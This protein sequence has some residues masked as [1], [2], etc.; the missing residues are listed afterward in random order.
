MIDIEMQKLRKLSK[1]EIINFFMKFKE[2]LSSH[3]SYLSNYDDIYNLAID[4]AISDI[5][6]ENDVDCNFTIERYLKKHI[7]ESLGIIF[8]SMQNERI[9]LFNEFLNSNLHFTASNKNN[10]EE[11][12][13]IADFFKDINYL[14]TTDNALEIIEGNKLL[15][16]SLKKLVDKNI[17]RI[18][19]DDFSSV[20]DN[21][22]LISFMEAYCLKNDISLVENMELT[23][24]YYETILDD[25]DS[26]CISDTVRAYLNTLKKT[27]LTP[28]EEF[29]LAKK[30]KQGDKKAETELIER[31]LRLV[32]AIAKHYVGRG[33]PFIDLIQEGNIGLIKAISKFDPDKGY[34]LSTY[35]T[36][37]IKQAVSR[38]I[39]DNSRTIRMPVHF[40]E[41]LNKYVK[42]TNIL[43]ERLGR[44]PTV[45]ELAKELKIPPDKV[46]KLYGLTVNSISINA[47][48]GANKDRE[49]EVFLADDKA[50]IEKDYEQEELKQNVKKLIENTNLSEQEE[51]V[52][53]L[54]FGIDQP[55]EQ[56]LSLETISKEFGVTRERIRQIEVRALKKL[57]RSRQINGL[58]IY[59]DN[60]EKALENLKASR[61]GLI[62]QNYQTSIIE[63]PNIKST[64]M[65]L[66]EILKDYKEKEIILAIEEII[67]DKFSDLN[68]EFK[69]KLKNLEIDEF[70]AS[71]I[72]EF[73]YVIAPIVKKNL[74]ENKNRESEMKLIN[75]KTFAELFEGYQTEKVIETIDG[76]ENGDLEIFK[77]RFGADYDENISCS[78]SQK[79]RTRLNN[80]IVTVKRKIDR[81]TKEKEKLLKKQ[82]KG[83]VVMKESLLEN[84]ENITPS[85][86]NEESDITVHEEVSTDTGSVTT[87]VDNLLEMFNQPEYIDLLKELNPLEYV[88]LALKLGYVTGENYSTSSIADFLK[89]DQAKVIESAKTGLKSYKEKILKSIDSIAES[90]TIKTY[91]KEK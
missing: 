43:S 6:K 33:L 27:L 12:S 66:P 35:A 32:V 9:K 5:L 78:L 7:D 37:W 51:L 77:K 68:D 15:E 70:S 41:K 2:E 17:Q 44:E 80:L 55:T 57:K 71:E 89:I 20:T 13:K 67:A 42:T 61:Q 29:S 56:A 74:E 26:T 3:Y 39:Y 82:E 47:F 50:S 75:M 34:K 85:I 1:E 84:K 31:N 83:E 90:D 38:S 76:L 60:P 65:L 87:P 11:F 59:M 79:E 22:I 30:A 49:L 18:R 10:I 25:I 4:K 16:K 48:V 19:E 24:E 28:E 62:T 81:Q 52:I 63:H 40:H 88:V 14:L 45:E 54:R 46:E 73:N 53:K 86:S 58:E 64:K 36:W 72:N 21:E 8:S 23:N 91:K 69:A